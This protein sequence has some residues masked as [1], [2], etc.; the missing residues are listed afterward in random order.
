MLFYPHQAFFHLLV[1]SQCDI[2]IVPLL[3]GSSFLQDALLK[4]K[5][6]FPAA[7]SSAT[8]LLFKSRLN[9]LNII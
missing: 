8:D 9:V 3:V 7:P 1:L 4:L 6:I 5:N 2:T